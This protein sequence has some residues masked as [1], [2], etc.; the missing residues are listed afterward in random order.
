MEGDWLSVGYYILPNLMDFT[1]VLQTTFDGVLSFS[2]SYL[3]E[4]VIIA[5]AIASSYFTTFMIYSW[6]AT[7]GIREIFLVC[8]QFID[9]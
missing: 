4:L 2:Y 9:L 6:L 1:M 5:I 3:M 8:L 7:F